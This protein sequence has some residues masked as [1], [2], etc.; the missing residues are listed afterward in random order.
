M[1]YITLSYYTEMLYEIQSFNY[2][3]LFQ[4][5]ISHSNSTVFIAVELWSSKSLW[6]TLTRF[7]NP[8]TTQTAAQ[9]AIK[10]PNIEPT[11]PK[12]M[13]AV[14]TSLF[15]RKKSKFFDE[16]SDHF[17]VRKNN[18]EKPILKKLTFCCRIDNRP[19]NL[20]KHSQKNKS[21]VIIRKSFMFNF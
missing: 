18:N 12:V 5:M 3:N 19:H 20:L 11:Q 16:N 7:L 6:Y 15:S 14:L 1:I 9:D 4:R 13:R 2:E 17:Y 8:K 10:R 21:P